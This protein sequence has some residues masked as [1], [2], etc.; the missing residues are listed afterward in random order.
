MANVL[1]F[2]FQ[3]L[4]LLLVVR[5]IAAMARSDTLHPHCQESCGNFSIPYP[6]GIGPG[7]YRDKSFNITCKENADGVMMPY[8]GG[9]N[10]SIPVFNFSVSQSQ[11]TMFKYLSYVCYNASGYTDVQGSGLRLE[12]TPFAISATRNKFTAMGC[13]TI[14]YINGTNGSYGSGCISFCN[15]LD[16]SASGS[17]TGVGCCQTSLPQNLVDYNSEFYGRGTN[18][19]TW[20]FNPCSYSF[21]ADQDWFE[22]DVSYLKGDYFKLKFH[23]GVPLVLDWVAENVTCA[24]AKK[25]NTSYA[26]RSSNSDCQNSH[27]GIGYTCK[28]SQGYEGNPYLEDGCQGTTSFILEPCNC[29][30]V[31]TVMQLIPMLGWIFCRYPGV[32]SFR[33]VSLLWHLREQGRWL[34]LLMR[35]RVS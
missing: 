20:E 13:K 26:C 6:F 7:C 1:P 32:R 29:Y 14:A 11:A 28:C 17:C 33:C 30:P 2:L 34:H 23:Q 4:L 15:K 21:V 8:S 22:F 5:T 27:H 19:N 35:A 3:L 10:S 24:Q 9:I 16:Y 12:G 25:N 31:M 18:D